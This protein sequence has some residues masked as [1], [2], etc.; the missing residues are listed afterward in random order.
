MQRLIALL[1]SHWLVLAACMVVS[2]GCAALYA[3]TRTVLYES[4]AV[5]AQSRDDSSQLSMSG[6]LASLGGLVGGLGIG[7]EETSVEESA[8]V[9][10]S[11]DF[12]LRFMREH[13]VLQF[14]FPKL[15]DSAARAWKVN[16]VPATPSLWSRLAEQLGAQPDYAA[17]HTHPPGP[18]SDDAVL[19]FDRLRVVEIDRRTNFVRLSVRGPTP[20]L[21]QAWAAQMIEEVNE[22]L[23]ARALQD[24]IRGVDVLSKRVE[25]E[26]EQSVRSIATALLE[27][28][29]RNEVAAQSR[30]EFAL[31]VLD[32]P[33]LPD[34][35]YYPRRTRMVVIGAGLGLL[36]GSAGVL[37]LTAWRGRRRGAADGS[38]P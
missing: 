1:W 6:G 34:Q 38:V 15:W 26:T 21:A 2:A 35:R 9:L 3:L 25:T 32:P 20:Q 37:A 23:R 29:L 5:L 18:S 10:R 30:S 27:A 28:Q 36:L 8:E 13:G 12:S 14:L 31:R 4:D 7:R 16:A 11:R 22:S 33:S 17:V 19:A 24:S